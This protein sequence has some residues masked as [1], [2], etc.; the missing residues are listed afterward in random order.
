MMHSDN[1]SHRFALEM[2]GSINFTIIELFY[3]LE[4]RPLNGGSIIFQD[5][6]SKMQSL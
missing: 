2:L 4:R 1:T 6:I 3:E 5:F